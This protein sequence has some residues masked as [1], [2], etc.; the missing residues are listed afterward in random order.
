ML[1]HL[2]NFLPLPILLV[3]PKRG[4]GLV[5]LLS[6]FKRVEV[7]TPVSVQL[8]SKLLLLVVNLG[9]VLPQLSCWTQLLGTE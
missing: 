2:F 1:E 4:C 3:P 9:V 5:F 7:V 6:S 8:L